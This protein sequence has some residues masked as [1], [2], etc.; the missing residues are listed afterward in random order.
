[1]TLAYLCTGRLKPEPVSAASGAPSCAKSIVGRGL[2]M[3]LPPVK[4]SSITF[5]PL[6]AALNNIYTSTG[7]CQ[8]LGSMHELVQAQLNA[9]DA[10]TL[11]ASNLQ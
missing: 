7:L 6:P 11:Q 2:I 3:R 4:L 10:K 5:L 8:R 1:M 9:T